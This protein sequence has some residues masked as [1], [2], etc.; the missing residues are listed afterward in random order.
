MKLLDARRLT[1]LNLQSTVPGPIVEVELTKPDE[2]KIFIDG[3]ASS[4]DQIRA[5]LD[6]EISPFIVRQFE[7]GLA[8]VAGAPIDALYASVAVFEW[9]ATSSIAKYNGKDVSDDLERVLVEVRATRDEERST[10]LME[11]I[12]EAQR[13]NIPYLWD[14]DEFSL[15]Y[16]EFSETWPRNKLPVATEVSWGDLK[17]I[18]TFLITGTNGKTTTARMTASILK[19]A[20]LSVGTS[21]TDGI[22]IDGEVVEKGDWTGPGAARFI[23][24]HPKVQIA[25]LETA[26]GGMLRRGLGISSCNAAAVTNI[27]ADHLGEYGIND[28]RGMAQVKTLVYKAV[29]SSGTC[30]INADDQYVM[31]LVEQ[32]G[33]THCY[34]SLASS[35]KLRTHVKNGGSA[36]WIEDEI[37][38]YAQGDRHFEIMKVGDIP[39][40]HG[41]A[42]RHNLSNALL[43]C[44]LVTTLGVD[45]EVIRAGLSSFGRNW[46]DNPGRCHVIEHNDVQIILDFAHNP[47][48]MRA[49]LSMVKSMKT[50]DGKMSICF[51]QAGDRSEQDLRDLVEVLLEFTPDQLVLRGLPETYHR[52]RPPE[53][54]ENLFREL[55]QEKEF[56]LSHFQSFENEVEA[57]KYALTWAKPGDTVIHL[58]HLERDA[59]RQYFSQLN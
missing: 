36:V 22:S 24:R 31:E 3:F 8:I 13:R 52:G 37:I 18:P 48:G 27:A 25:V 55:L 7:S 56:P 38:H 50:P 28:E 2:S 34:T 11:L 41:G 46:H 29:D 33:Q 51:A 1:G 4:L 59:I 12:A 43:A 53:E 14:D 10:S 30:V 57:L 15:G 58:V 23:L 35:P 42:A 17:A 26:R 44:A 40:V 21:S 6:F 16:G 9:A 20:G 54:S 39:A 47:H 49:V 45:R 5:H 19:A 32:F